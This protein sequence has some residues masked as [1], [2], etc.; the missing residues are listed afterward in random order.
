MGG[1]T[2]RRGTG[3]GSGSGSGWTLKRDGRHR[4]TFDVIGFWGSVVWQRQ[5][6]SGKR[7]GSTRI[8]SAHCTTFSR[9]CDS[10]AGVASST[11]S[12]PVSLPLA[13]PLCPCPKYLFYFLFICFFGFLSFLCT[14][15]VHLI[16]NSKLCLSQTCK[17]PCKWHSRCNG[18]G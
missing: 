17:I 4:S 3:F 5:V 9:T 1:R 6:A 7:L 11:V 10:F 14:I 18:V 16:A 15:S 2:D 13:L 12:V 8:G